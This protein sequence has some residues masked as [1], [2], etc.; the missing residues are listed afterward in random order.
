MRARSP[1]DLVGGSA[2]TR[3]VT[4]SRSTTLRAHVP[5]PGSREISRE[6]DFRDSEVRSRGSTVDRVRL[7]PSGPGPGTEEGRRGLLE[8]PRRRRRPPDH[9]RRTAPHELA[10]SDRRRHPRGTDRRLLVLRPCPGHQRHGRRDPRPP[11][12]RRRTRR[13]GRVLRDGARHAGRGAAGDDEVVRHQLPLSGARVGP[14][15]RLHRR[16]HQAGLG[17]EGGPRAGPHR[18]AGARRPGHLSPARQARPGC[19]GR[20]R[21]ADPPGPPA[22]GVRGGPRRPARGGRGVGAAGRARSSRTA[23]PPN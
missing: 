6:G 1:G 19:R 4:T 7:P 3:A 15:Y 11:P 17:V 13:A 14:G 2:Y 22:A 9:R 5:P 8:G 20:L 10:A 12:H 21:T 23:P 18:P 16:L